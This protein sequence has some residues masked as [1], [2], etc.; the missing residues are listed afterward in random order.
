M[1]FPDVER[2]NHVITLLILVQLPIR[3][4]L[5]ALSDNLTKRLLSLLPRYRVTKH[6]GDIQINR[7]F[8]LTQD[9]IQLLEV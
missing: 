3:L 7:S 2:Q 5:G 6:K 9:Q 1:M 8:L 4:K